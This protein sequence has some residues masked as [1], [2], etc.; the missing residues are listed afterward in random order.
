MPKYAYYNGLADLPTPVV[1]WYDTDD[2]TYDPMPAEADLF[3][4]TEEEWADRL[5][6]S[7]SIDETGLVATITPALTW[8]QELATRVDAGITL[9]SPST[10]TIDGLW[11]L[12]T[13]TIT[14]LSTVA[15][16]ENAG[17]GL[18]GQLGT[19]T[20]PNAAG[21]PIELTAANVADIMV[22]M[23][24]MVFAIETQAAIMRLGGTPVWPDQV[25]TID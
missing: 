15:L 10:P 7:W 12:D 3:Q 6:G 18:P 19:F 2:F 21:D 8:D 9:T 5:T 23:R 17:Y 22:A 20:Y 25:A 11:T 13:F 1:G 14:Q 24:D 4:L 16:H